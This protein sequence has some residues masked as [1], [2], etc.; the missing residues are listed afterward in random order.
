MES[1]SPGKENLK[2]IYTG[3]LAGIIGPGLF[4]SV[5]IVLTLLED[6]F[7]RSLGWS[8]LS[9]STTEWPSGLA[10][11]EYGYIMSAA[12]LVNGIM[13]VL[14]GLGLWKALP[15]TTTPRVATALLILNSSLANSPPLTFK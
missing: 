2:L 12:F 5:L 9:L 3:G 11:R 13:V 10:L 1:R 7:M 6:D 8:P 14:F 15:P 4:G